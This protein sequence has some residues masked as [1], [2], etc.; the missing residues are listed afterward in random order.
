MLLLSLF[1]DH[2]IIRSCAAA[3]PQDRAA[4]TLY[5]SEFIIL[6]SLLLC[7]YEPNELERYCGRSWLKIFSDSFPIIWTVW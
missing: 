3:G 2:P 6:N 4:G 5:N 1:M 7:L